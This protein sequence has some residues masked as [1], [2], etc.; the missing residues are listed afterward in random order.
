MGDFLPV[1]RVYAT[2]AGEEC[3]VIEERFDDAKT[4]ETLVMTT[5]DYRPVTWERVTTDG[6]TTK[7]RIVFRTVE[8]ADLDSVPQDFFDLDIV[9]DAAKKAGARRA[10]EQRESAPQ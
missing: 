1:S 10:G 8:Q 6:A 2:I 9:T 3:W 5:S 4:V 7:K